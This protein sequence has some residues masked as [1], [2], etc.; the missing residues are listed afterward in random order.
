MAAMDSLSRLVNLYLLLANSPRPLTLEQIVSSIGGF[1]DSAA[2]RRQAFERAKRDLRSLG[3]PIRTLTGPSGVDAYKVDERD[4]NAPAPSLTP[5]EALALAG[6]MASV[7]FGRGD[8]LDS[9]GK[10][11]CLYDGEV[12]EL[13]NFPVV[14]GVSEFF[15]AI[16]SRS[17]V[18]FG[19][20]G[21]PRVACPYAIV[22]R[23]ANWYLLAREEGS[24]TPKSFRVDL[25]EGAVE[26]LSRQCAVPEGLDLNQIIPEKRSAISEG[27]PQD[28][29]VRYPE[30]LAEVVEGNLPGPITSVRTDGWVI[31][32]LRVGSIGGFMRVVVEFSE[33]MGIEGP[34]EFKSSAREWLE[35]AVA[36]QR[37][38]MPEAAALERLLEEARDSE[39]DAKAPSRQARH[40]TTIDQFRKVMG[41]LPWLY[42]NPVTTTEEISRLFSIEEERVGDLL[43]R[44]A[45]CG[46]PPFTPDQL[47]EIVVEGDEISARISEDFARGLVL[48]QADLFVIALS[49]RVALASGEFEGRTELESALEKIFGSGSAEEMVESIVVDIEGE[50]YL[51]ALRAGIEG[52]RQ[53]RFDYLASGEASLAARVVDPFVVF[54]DQGFWYLRA[55]CHRSGGVRNFRLDRMENVQ[56]TDDHVRHQP[57]A[58]DLLH[59]AFSLDE[60]ELHLGEQVLVGTA[61]GRE[62]LLAGVPHDRVQADLLPGWELHRLRVVSYPWL[63]KLAGSAGGSMR[64]VYPQAAVA[65]V[66]SQL[67][68]MRDR[69][70]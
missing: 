37:A 23:W 61:A 33:T 27:E 34:P 42:R 63:A 45:C 12:A 26:R 56:V 8:A 51:G 10:L 7:R 48:S 55:W 43:E 46:L 40:L 9:A 31:S 65:E 15:E 35:A 32:T 70:V 22:F 53:V 52:Q 2:A 68:T 62:W 3:L 47:I 41:I 28:V 6:A 54:S 5:L 19:Y 20:R 39:G 67:E 29:V 66:T 21:R 49:A 13:A 57:N 24:N 50:R 11:G 38:E 69:L 25:V 36:A 44:V 1:P 14:P 59:S 64:V 18:A 17:M 30:V 16:T 58:G 4:A 60:G